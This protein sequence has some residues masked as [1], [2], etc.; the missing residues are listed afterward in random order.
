MRQVSVMEVQ[1]E[2][3]T[4]QTA[5][6]HVDQRLL[7]ETSKPGDLYLLR[8]EDQDSFLS[9][10]WQESDPARLLTPSGHSR[11]LR[12]VAERVVRKNWTFEELSGDLGKSETQ[13]HPKWFDPCARINREFDYAQFGWLALVPATDNERLQSP[14]GSFYLF[15][16]MHKSLVLATRLLRGETQ[17]RPVEALYLLPRR[18]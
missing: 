8:L 1:N 5:G 4:R 9:L 2:L 15:D 10:I 12:E 13:H 7:T 6:H 16:G 3:A 17:Y 14:F 18:R 11:T